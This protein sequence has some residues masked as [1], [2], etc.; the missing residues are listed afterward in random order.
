[1]AP[2]EASLP[3][4]PSVSI[5]VLAFNEAR[6]LPATIASIHQAVAG[7]FPAYEIII[8]NDGSRDDT[9]RVAENLA[10]EDSR[11]RVI[12]N[13]HNRGCGYT[14]FRGAAAASSDY[15]WLIP[16]D[17]EIPAD[18]METIASHIGM[19]DMV[20]PYVLNTGIRPLERR[21][22]SRGYTMLINA[23]F[24]KR[25]RYYNGPCVIRSE[26]VRSV[27][28]VYSRG[29]AFLATILLR[30]IR[31]K[32]SYVQVGIRLQP[33]SFGKPSI[34]SWHNIFNAARTIARLYWDINIAE[35]FKKAKLK[36]SKTAP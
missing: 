21:I 3:V 27:P 11:L 19:V 10:R 12:H 26:L 8:V 23:L 20:I 25:L 30:L 2:S 13:P 6:S 9:V 33:R 17:G 36:P 16:G 24:L 18:S 15:V 31:R 7:K 14:F 22:I 1:M 5:V 35:Y 29:F 28:P 32:H 34:G 4:A